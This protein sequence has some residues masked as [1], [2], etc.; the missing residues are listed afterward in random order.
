MRNITPEFATTLP[1]AMVNVMPGQKQRT[2]KLT[3][4]YQVAGCVY[5]AFTQTVIQSEVELILKFSVHLE[6]DMK[7]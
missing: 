4:F 2:T 5:T 1:R 7:R 3:L 6:K